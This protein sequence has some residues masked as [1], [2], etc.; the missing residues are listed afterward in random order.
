M[1]NGGCFVDVFWLKKQSENTFVKT[2]YF[3]ILVP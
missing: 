3:F 1:G 2:G